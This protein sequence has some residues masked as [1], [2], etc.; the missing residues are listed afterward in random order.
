MNTSKLNIAYETPSDFLKVGSSTG[1]RT[2]TILFHFLAGI[3]LAAFLAPEGTGIATA[4]VGLAVLAKA[5]Y[6]Y[7][8]SGAINLPNMAALAAGGALS[9]IAAPFIG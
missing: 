6:D 2:L 7:V 1:M 8:E 9:L 3:A 4:S 5:V